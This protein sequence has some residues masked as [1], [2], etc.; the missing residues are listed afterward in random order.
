VTIQFI[1]PEQPSSGVTPYRSL[2][3]QTAPAVEPVTLAEAKTQCRVD[4]ADDDAYISTL[5]ATARLYVED[6]LDVSLITTVWETRYDCFPLWEIIL[7]RPPMQNAA[8]TVTYRDEGGTVR[9]LSSVEYQVDHYV[10]PG[11]IYPKF[12]GV[13][14]AV[15]GD[16]N[17]VVVRWSAGYGASGSSVP[18]VIKHAIL[19]LVSHWYE[20][21]Q[22]VSQG[23]QMP[24]PATFDTLMAASGWGGY[25]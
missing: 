5:I 23:M 18:S 12:E 4:T 1:S 13:W 14:P 16:E 19:L 25:R 8:V 22:P 6:V 7:P 24:I 20:T 15:R 2:F 11:R 10:T 17:S 9:T 21:R 3:R